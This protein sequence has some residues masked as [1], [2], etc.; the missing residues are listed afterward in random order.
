HYPPSSEH[1]P[2]SSEHYPPSSEHYQQ[3]EAIAE[4]IRR[5]GRISKD[6]VRKVILELC[7][8]QY[9]PLGTLA[10]LLGREPDTIRNHYVNPM[11]DEGLLEL[12]H[13][14]LRNHPQ[15]AYRTVSRSHFLSAQDE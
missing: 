14:Q 5:K 7:S 2:P 12:K 15:Q 3:L 9:L 8:Q 11:I 13:P 1:Y 10:Q 4:P 6:S